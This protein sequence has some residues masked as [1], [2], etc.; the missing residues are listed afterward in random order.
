MEKSSRK[1]ALKS[2]PRPILILVINP[3]QPFHARYSFK[4]KI[5]K[6]DYLKKR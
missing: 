1:Y 5:W 3:K 6:E 2:S 4:N